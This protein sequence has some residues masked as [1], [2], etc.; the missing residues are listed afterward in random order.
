MFLGQDDWEATRVIATV[1][2]RASA[3]C[4]AVVRTPVGEMAYR[5]DTAVLCPTA[6]P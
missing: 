4:D 6:S 1:R 5:A 3:N 2:R